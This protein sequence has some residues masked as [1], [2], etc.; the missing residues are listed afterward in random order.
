[1]QQHPFEHAV[2]LRTVKLT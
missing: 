1:M 2:N